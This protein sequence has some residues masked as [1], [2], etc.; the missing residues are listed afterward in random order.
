MAIGSFFNNNGIGWAMGFQ[1]EKSS[2]SN[3]MV[4]PEENDH[5]WTNLTHV[6]SWIPGL[7][8]IAGV[9][10][11]YKAHE[12]K[13]ICNTNETDELD[14]AKTLQARA[15]ASFLQASVILFAIDIIATISRFSPCCQPE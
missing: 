1:T 11:L 10:Y 9:Y 15:V 4:D 12:A 6:L 2:G 8:I 13:E 14:Y 5:I 7:S 3:S